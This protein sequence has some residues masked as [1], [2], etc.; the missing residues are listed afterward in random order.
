M[1]GHQ[2]GVAGP[3]WSGAV[4]VPAVAAATCGAGLQHRPCVNPFLA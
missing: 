4:H 1:P 2:V 3:C